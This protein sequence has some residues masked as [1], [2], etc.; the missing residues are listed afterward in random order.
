MCLV[1]RFQLVFLIKSNNGEQITT[2]QP[3]RGHFQVRIKVFFFH[4]E[5]QSLKEIPCSTVLPRKSCAVYYLPS[6][7]FESFEGSP[8]QISERR[9]GPIRIALPIKEQKPTSGM[10]SL[11]ANAVRWPAI[12]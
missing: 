2:F 9:K 4:E 10:S 3:L 5:W 12:L 11:P 1:Q 8:T 6:H 7:C